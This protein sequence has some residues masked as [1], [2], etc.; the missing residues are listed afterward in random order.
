V[1]LVRAS[2]LNLNAQWPTCSPVNAIALLRL[3]M[4]LSAARLNHRRRNNAW[5][6]RA[7]PNNFYIVVKLPAAM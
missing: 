2:A 6:A 7:R 1:A 5:D 4:K 3:P